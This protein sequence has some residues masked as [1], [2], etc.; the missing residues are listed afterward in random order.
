MPKPANKQ[1]SSRRRKELQLKRV[2]TVIF[3]WSLTVSLSSKL[4]LKRFLKSSHKN[5]HFISRQDSQY[6]TLDDLSKVREHCEF[7]G[8]PHLKALPFFSSTLTRWAESLHMGALQ[9]L[10][11]FI[12]QAT[13]DH[14]TINLSTFKKLLQPNSFPLTQWKSGWHWVFY[15]TMWRS[16]NLRLLHVELRFPVAPDLWLDG[17]TF[18]AKLLIK[19]ARERLIEMRYDYTHYAKC[20]NSYT[21]EIHWH[22]LEQLFTD[23]N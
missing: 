19:V 1:S 21:Q 10:C 16:E 20:H 15:K 11:H 22:I 14:N 7:A 4:R 13:Q 2:K 18:L 8:W 12:C 17:P 9:P 23:C 3:I 5:I 6:V